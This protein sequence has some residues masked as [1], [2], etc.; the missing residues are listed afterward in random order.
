M[1]VRT[2][3]SCALGRCPSL[4]MSRE[5]KTETE[6][7]NI[8]AESPTCRR[9]WHMNICLSDC[10][11]R[12]MLVLLDL[13]YSPP[14]SYPATPIRPLSSLQQPPTSPPSVSH[15]PRDN[16]VR[17]GGECFYETPRSIRNTWK[18]G[19]RTVVDRTDES[20]SSLMERTRE[21]SSKR[22]VVNSRIGLESRSRKC[23]WQPLQDFDT[24]LQDGTN[25]TSK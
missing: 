11:P 12:P 16:F 23:G 17:V 14:S 5:R 15:V 22:L 6:M 1:R 4:Y 25:L 10:S 13:C 7:K 21:S 19:I 2:P 18:L 20:R 9:R 8:R 3:S 24:N